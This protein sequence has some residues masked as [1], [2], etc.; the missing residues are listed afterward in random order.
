[1]LTPYSFTLFVDP[2]GNNST[3]VI[4]DY[5]KPWQTINAAI[6]Y[7]GTSSQPSGGYTIHVFR[8]NYTATQSVTYTAGKS[9]SL[10]FEPNANLSVA[11]TSVGYWFTHDGGTSSTVDVCGSGRSTNSITSNY[12]VFKIGDGN[13]QPDATSC[14]L[15]INNISIYS[16]N[17]AN[18]SASGNGVVIWA[19]ESTVKIDNS[20]IAL[21]S[22]GALNIYQYVIW[23]NISYLYVMGSTIEMNSNSVQTSY[24]SGANVAG[25]L[26]YENAAVTTNDV[27]RIRLQSTYLSQWGPWGGGAILTSPSGSTTG[28]INLSNVYFHCVGAS[29]VWT[30]Y[31]NSNG[32]EDRVFI[33]GS[34]VSGALKPTEL[35]SGFGAV[36]ST[37]WFQI[38]TSASGLAI[39]QA[40]QTNRPY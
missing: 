3:A 17:S 34:V 27:G 24:A 30:V 19:D 16:S 28:T 14:T 32:K 1:M 13:T 22:V 40:G 25:W 18:Y 7:A 8:G 15:D 23:L 36:G 31:N 6:N 11:L 21:T 2:S 20:I 10:F 12:G 4:G 26:I 33:G 37:F 38:P 35:G 29:K 9:L 5:T 39:Y